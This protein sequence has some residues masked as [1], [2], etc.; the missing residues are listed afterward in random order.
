M[1]QVAGNATR[2]AKKAVQAS[3]ID[4]KYVSFCVSAL[5]KSAESN[6]SNR[7]LTNGYNVNVVINTITRN[8]ANTVTAFVRLCMG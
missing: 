7:V 3:S 6:A 8:T 2:M 5:P 4:G 1:N